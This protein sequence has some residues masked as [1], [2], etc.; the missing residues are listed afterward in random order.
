MIKVLT[1]LFTKK[2]NPYNVTQL[3]LS[4]VPSEEH[5]GKKFIKNQ[6]WSPFNKDADI[7]N[8]CLFFKIYKNQ[9]LKNLFDIIPQSNCQYRTRN[10]QNI[11][12]MNVKHQFYK[13]T[14]FLSTIVEQNRSDQKAIPQTMTRAKSPSRAQ[15]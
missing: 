11:P 4:Q 8:Y 2:M 5:R 7:E 10:A 13:N 9:C 6:V 12:H 3:Q 14:Y 1:I 15:I